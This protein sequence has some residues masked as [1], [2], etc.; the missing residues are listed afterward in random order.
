MIFKNIPSTKK[1]NEISNKIINLSSEFKGI[2][3]SN[4]KEHNFDVVLDEIEFST[5]LYDLFFYSQVMKVKYSDFFI[6]TTVN[7]ILISLENFINKNGINIPKGYLQNM[8][9]NLSNTLHKINNSAK[10]QD[11]DGLFLVAGYYCK[12][13][14]RLNE[15]DFEEDEILI[16]LIANHFLKIINIPESD[17]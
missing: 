3:I 7:T 12:D 6:E 16:E 8:F 11:I 5:F 14:L 9:K 13:E 17:I 15:N 1:A 2:I 10:E 4:S